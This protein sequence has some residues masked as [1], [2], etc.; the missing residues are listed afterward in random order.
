M[1]H[2]W[3]IICCFATLVL[4]CGT[5]TPP[6]GEEVLSV[7]TEGGDSTENILQLDFLDLDTVRRTYLVFQQ[8]LP[9]AEMNGF[10]ALEGRRLAEEALEANVIPTGPLTSLFYRWDT[11]AGMGEAAVALPVEP[12]TKMPP[13]VTI[14]LPVTK[15]LALDLE[16]SYQRLSAFHVALGDELARRNLK[17]VLP[18]IEEYYV[19]P[20]QT[21]DPNEFRT[22]VIYPYT[23]PE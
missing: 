1:L 22:R 12:G 10:L 6:A 19:G 3:L 18:S 9:F 7:T 13:Y 11:E 2:R 5:E 8:E 17:P 21:R 23:T 4:N 16:G 15:S 20:L 14:T